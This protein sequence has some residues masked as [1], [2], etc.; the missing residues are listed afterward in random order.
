MP[1]DSSNSALADILIVD[2]TPDNIRFLSAMLLEQGYNVR[3]AL[4]GQMA[5]TASQSLPPDLI[6]L[7]INMPDMNGYEVCRQLKANPHTQPIPVIFLSALDDVIDKVKAFQVGGVDYVTKPFQFEEVLVRVQTQLT[8]QNLQN[9]LQAQNQQLQETLVELKATQAQLIQ[10]EKMIGLGQLV[11]GVAH[12]INNPIS[13][14]SGNIG[15]ARRY[16]KDLLNLLSIYQQTYPNPTSEIQQIC[17]DIDLDFLIADLQ[18]LLGSMQTGVDRIHTIML[19]LRIFSRLDE[20][21][22]KAVD[23]HEGLDSTLLLLEHR[24]RPSSKIA[25]IK[26]VKNYGTL[27]AVT[28]YARQMNQV[29]LQLLTNAIEAL[30]VREKLANRQN[31]DVNPACIWITTEVMDQTSVIIRLRDNAL[32][33]PENVRSRIF[34]PFFTTKTV[35][36]GAGLGLTTSYQVVV[37]KHHGHLTYE[38][39]VGEGTEFIIEIPVHI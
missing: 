39:V 28:C 35:G 2:D 15:P 18:K 13:F 1:Q 7:D 4:N 33:I 8:M 30:E 32:G 24:F 23:L 17:E 14:I 3:K 22:I 20:S 9:R 26:I 16:I 6:L 25:G 19:A 34:D 11:A 5:L 21:D 10:K 29:F 37:D 38:S 27:P 12:E 36:Q 31:L